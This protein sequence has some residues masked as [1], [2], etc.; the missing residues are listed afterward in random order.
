[1]DG[2]RYNGDWF[3]DKQHG[4]GTEL[5]TDGAVYQGHFDCGMKN[6]QGLF[7]WPD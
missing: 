3:D 6:G 5:W 4:V 2:A 1:L 7:K